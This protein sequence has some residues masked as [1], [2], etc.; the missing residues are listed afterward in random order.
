MLNLPVYLYTPAIRVFLDLENS[1]ERGVDMMYHGYVKIA[2]GLTNTIRFNFVNG[3][4]RAISINDKEFVFKLFDSYTNKEMLSKDITVMDDGT[5]PSLRGKTRL[6]IEGED[7]R[8][9]VPGHYEYSL[10]RKE[11]A[12]LHPLFIDGA[13]SM[14]GKVLLEDGITAKYIAS[15]E[16]GFLKGQ[17]D[18][19]T[20]GPIA[21]NRDGRGNNLLHTFQLYFTDFTGNF[22][23]YATLDNSSS[24]PNWVE[25]LDTDYVNQTDNVVINI[26]DMRNATYFKFEYTPE[27][28]S[29]DKILFRS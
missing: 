22:K 26:T 4:Q 28:G 18:L 9:L 29:I 2:K 5:T 19:Y 25:I 1:T 24:N 3:D 13:S 11:G 8:D 23:T 21:T 16:I 14:Q 20:A 27:D 7:T 10:L 17:N 6:I 12:K 15:E